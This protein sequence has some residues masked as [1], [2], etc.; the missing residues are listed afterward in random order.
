MHSDGKM[1]QLNNNKS[2]FVIIKESRVSLIFTKIL[3]KLNIQGSL[4][5]NSL[6]SFMAVPC[7]YLICPQSLPAHDR[8]GLIDVDRLMDVELYVQLLWQIALFA[9]HKCVQGYYENKSIS[10]FKTWS[11]TKGKMCWLSCYLHLTSDASFSYTCFA[12][13]SKKLLRD[14]TS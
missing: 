4:F 8:D 6:L 11:K 14:C 3:S 10:F 12:N 5:A 2:I 1:I 13:F 9:V 7:S